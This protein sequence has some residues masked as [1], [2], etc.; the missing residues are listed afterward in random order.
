MT[1]TVFYFTFF[2]EILE[3]LD[4]AGLLAKEESNFLQIASSSC[5]WKMFDV[6]SG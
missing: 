3:S 5:C 2:F 6:D 1:E 4:Q